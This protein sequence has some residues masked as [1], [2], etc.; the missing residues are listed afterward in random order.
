[1]KNLLMLVFSVFLSVS[2]STTSAATL[3][4]TEGLAADFDAGTTFDIFEVIWDAPSVLADQ[5]R[6][7]IYS[8]T[9]LT[10]NVIGTRV[11]DFANAG[12]GTM[13][14]TTSGAGSIG[15]IFATA[16]FGTISDFTFRTVF[17]VRSST[18][19]VLGSNEYD[20]IYT[21]SVVPLP[22]GLPLLLLAIG[23]LGVLRIRR[24]ITV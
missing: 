21:A 23:S 14:I 7:T 10:G 22:A 6:I 24:K 20:A 8:G 18:G 5:L 16:E 17:Q 15:S 11:L 4:P 1:M 12:F 13:Y 19:G 3:S 2:A 9:G